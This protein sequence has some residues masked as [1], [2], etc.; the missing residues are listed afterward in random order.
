MRWHQPLRIRA[1]C[2][3]QRR[4]GEHPLPTTLSHIAPLQ[5]SIWRR[6]GELIALFFIIGATGFGGP[7]VLIA[8]MEDEVVRRRKWMSR[9][10]FL[11]LVGATNLIPGPNAV[12]MSIHVGYMR[13][14]IPGLFAAG[15]AFVVPAVAVTMVIAW[16]YTRFGSLPSVAPFLYG[17][18]PVIIAVIISAVALGKPAVRLASGG[19]WPGGRRGN[20][21]G[22]K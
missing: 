16:A 14:G 8:M 9:Q 10:Y 1:L 11:D 15:I 7:A 20:A 6:L 18:K 2:G 17:I 3:V 13:A 19:D 22:R 21:G 4:P 5:G 12:E